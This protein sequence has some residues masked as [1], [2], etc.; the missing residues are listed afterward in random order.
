M[1]SLSFQGW[2]CNTSSSRAFPEIPLGSINIVGTEDIAKCLERIPEDMQ[3]LKPAH[4]DL[5]V[6]DWL[7]SEAW[8]RG[9]ANMID[10]ERY[11]SKCLA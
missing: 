4:G 8:N 1:Y 6:N 3:R 11:I 2:I 7:C 5:N 10:A 9:R